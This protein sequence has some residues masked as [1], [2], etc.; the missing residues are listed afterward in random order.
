MSECF[1]YFLPSF[2]LVYLNFYWNLETCLHTLIHLYN[3]PPLKPLKYSI[4]FVHTF[5]T[6][7][8][9]LWFSNLI[10]PVQPLPLRASLTWILWSVGWNQ[11]HQGE[12]W[13]STDQHNICTPWCSVY[14]LAGPGGGRFVRSRGS[15][16]VY[17]LWNSWK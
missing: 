16:D 8:T 13:E 1:D 17:I 2:K 15:R 7:T 9:P 10:P 5:H 4:G 3:T 14:V 11:C 6:L 12:G